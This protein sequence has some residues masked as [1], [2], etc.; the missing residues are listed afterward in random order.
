LVTELDKELLS[1]DEFR[2]IFID[3]K[4]IAE[5]RSIELANNLDV[6]SLTIGKLFN[7]MRPG[8]FWKVGGALFGL[9]SG[10]AV[11]AYWVG[12]TFGK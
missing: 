2:G 5:K 12:K 9:L 6:K 1:S 8:Q 10:I 4:R 7:G 11:A 3:W